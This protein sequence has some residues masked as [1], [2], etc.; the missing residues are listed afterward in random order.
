MKSNRRVFPNLPKQKRNKNDSYL[1]PYS[2]IQQLL[3]REDFNKD[4]TFLEP[5]CSK[6]RTI[7]ETLKRNGFTNITCNIFDEDGIDF[8]LWDEN[9]KYDYIITNTP[10]GSI[11]TEL[12]L[13]MKKI[14]T[15]KFAVLFPIS[16]LNGKK[17]YDRIYKD[18]DFPLKKIYQFVRFPLL[19]DTVR[20]D[21]CYYTGMVL[22][23]WFIYE[24]GYKGSIMLEQI[25]ND[26]WCLGSKSWKKKN[27]TCPE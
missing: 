3:D 13:K 9:N 26:E 12:I 22:Y 23:G 11:S 5:C 14:V 6:E 2:M 25:D 15:K 17:R 18:K 7:P 10:Y 19:I 21:G 8:R 20:K 16:N 4:G 1:T 24:K 27:I